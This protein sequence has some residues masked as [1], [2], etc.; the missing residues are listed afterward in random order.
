MGSLSVHVS[1]V[2]RGPGASPS[3]RIVSLV[4]SV[5]HLL[6]PARVFIALFT[7]APRPRG[8]SDKRLL[9]DLRYTVLL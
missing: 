5:D 1:S 6:T 9:Y 8:S 3:K 2:V 4:R 7:F